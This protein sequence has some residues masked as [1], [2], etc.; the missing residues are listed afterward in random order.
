VGLF[1]PYLTTGGDAD[2]CWR[3]LRET[4]WKLEFAPQAIIRHRHRLN[5]REFRSQWR[6]Y[7]YSNRYLHELY[8]V[9]LMRDFTL[10]ELIYRFSRWLFKE[11]PR[12]GY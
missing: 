2:I 1:R 8:G 5:L 10:R 11:I 12:E 3:I 7:G 9:A 4:D 6:R